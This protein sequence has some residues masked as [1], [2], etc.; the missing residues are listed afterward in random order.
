MRRSLV[1]ISSH[2]DPVS[3][4]ASHSC[5]PGSISRTSPASAYRRAALDWFD[6]VVLLTDVPVD[7]TE[8][9][10]C[11]AWHAAPD[12]LAT[13][14]ATARWLAMVLP[15]TLATFYFNDLPEL[16]G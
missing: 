4:Y 1:I 7:T 6:R 11:L 16:Y 2:L 15:K 8:L 10:L 12:R 13:V 5:Q 9:A 3:K 14:L